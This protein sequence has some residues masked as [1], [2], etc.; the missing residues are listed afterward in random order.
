MYKCFMPIGVS[1]GAK[2]MFFRLRFVPNGNEIVPNKHFDEKSVASE[3][4][5]SIN[6]CIFVVDLTKCL[7]WPNQM[8]ASDVKH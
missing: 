5:L 7:P 8:F 1:D 4:I 6:V 2:V 3:D